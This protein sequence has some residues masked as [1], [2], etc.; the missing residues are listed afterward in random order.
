MRLTALATLQL[1]ACGLTS[2]PAALAALAGSLTSLALSHNDDLQLANDDIVTLLALGKL[3]NLDLRKSHVRKM[4]HRPVCPMEAEFLKEYEEAAETV[5]AFL[6]Y[7]PP[8]W[9]PDSL[10]HLVNL[11]S[12]FRVHHGRTLALQVR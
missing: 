1:E 5:A 3:Q 11:P 6:Q 8:L 7:R 4:N 9:S 12:A 10:Q 2:I